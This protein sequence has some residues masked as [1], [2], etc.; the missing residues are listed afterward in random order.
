MFPKSA[1]LVL[2]FVLILQVNGQP[3]KINCTNDEDCP[4]GYQ[5]VVHNVINIDP[6]PAYC[7]PRNEL[8]GEPGDCNEPPVGCKKKK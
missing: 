1:I 7:E 4:S 5:C 2:L 6:P 3:D 8:R